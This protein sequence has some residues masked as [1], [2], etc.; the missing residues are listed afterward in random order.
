M[1][2]ENQEKKIFSL[3][4]KYKN[5]NRVLADIEKKRAKLIAQGNRSNELF[6]VLEAHIEVADAVA[7]EIV[8]LLPTQENITSGEKII[9][10]GRL[11]DLDFTFLGG[12][13]FKILGKNLAIDQYRDRSDESSG[14]LVV[15]T[16]VESDEVASLKEENYIP[17]SETEVKIYRV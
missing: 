17:T 4:D 16:I 1:E 12:N 10:R 2:F 3:L 9:W 13:R 8:E 14:N 6:N 7:E 15:V 11:S 5:N